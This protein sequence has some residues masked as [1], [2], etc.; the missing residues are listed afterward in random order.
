[1]Q[2][3]RPIEILNHA[4]GHEEVRIPVGSQREV[5]ALTVRLNQARS[6]E[7]RR[8]EKQ[9]EGFYS[10]CPLW[11]LSVRKGDGEVIITNHEF[12][13]YELIVKN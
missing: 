13:P 1:V 10:D 4:M 3:T 6:Q 12:Q 8:F 5:H 9:G 2:A 7:A 11:N